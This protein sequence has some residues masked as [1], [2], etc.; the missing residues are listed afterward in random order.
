MKRTFTLFVTCATCV[1]SAVFANATAQGEEEITAKPATA[2]N[3]D[4]AETLPVPDDVKILPVP[5]PQ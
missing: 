5:A 4:D 3:Q 1:V 2:F